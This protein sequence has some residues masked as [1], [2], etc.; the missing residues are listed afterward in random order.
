MAPVSGPVSGAAV[1]V[2]LAGDLGLPLVTLDR[3]QRRRADGV[4]EVESVE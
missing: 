4:V 2:A 1:Y 3:E